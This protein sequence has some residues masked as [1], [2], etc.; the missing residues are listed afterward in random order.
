MIAMGVFELFLPN[1]CFCWGQ[2]QLVRSACTASVRQSQA[3]GERAS[4]CAPCQPNNLAFNTC[5]ILINFSQQPLQS[6]LARPLTSLPLDHPTS[7]P[8]RHPGHPKCTES[9]AGNPPTRFAVTI[10]LVCAST[11]PRHAHYCTTQHVTTK[12]LTSVQQ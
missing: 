2:T 3:C 4:L 12:Q 7:G 11:A 6:T 5:R 8:P 1:L 10:H 9:M